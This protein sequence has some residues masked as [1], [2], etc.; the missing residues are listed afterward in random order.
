[1]PSAV[2]GFRLLELM[3]SVANVQIGKTPLALDF[4]QNY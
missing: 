4:E 1:M 3:E 2:T